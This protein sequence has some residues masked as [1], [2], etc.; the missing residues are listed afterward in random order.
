MSLSEWMIG[1][2]LTAMAYA[3]FHYYCLPHVVEFVG[4]VRAWLK[5]WVAK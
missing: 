1:I 2:V 3:V 4:R 5:T